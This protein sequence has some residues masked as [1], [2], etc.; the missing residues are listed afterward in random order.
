MPTTDHRRAT[1][2]ENE[3]RRTG[4]PPRVGCSVGRTADSLRSTDRAVAILPAA[5]RSH[6]MGRAKLL[7]PFG[8]DTIVGTVVTT[9]ERAAVRPI[10]L[11]LRP[12]TGALR[13]WAR[14]RSLFIVDNMEPERGMLSSIVEG[15]RGLG[16]A[17]RLAASL[18][19]N[20]ACLLIM[21]ADL[22]AL[23]TATVNR[24]LDHQADC[25]SGIVLPTWQGRRG[26]PLLVH[27]RLVPAIETLDPAIGLRQLRELF[28]LEVETVE[29]ED[30]GVL[31]DVDTAEDYRRLKR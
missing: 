18:A 12:E 31:H 29:T 23:R 21:P 25:D 10:V 17:R 14:A 15:I 5:G 6:R 30:S 11:V 7:L 24:L 20:R 26:H 3:G 27:P 8:E 19:R 22:P 1:G 16:G 13:K 9:L 4:P 28:P 2:P